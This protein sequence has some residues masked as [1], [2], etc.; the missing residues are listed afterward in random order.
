[1]KT[2]QVTGFG[3]PS[4]PLPERR[5]DAGLKTEEVRSAG[6]GAHMRVDVRTVAAKQEGCADAEAFGEV[7]RSSVGCH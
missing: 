2:S 1:M 4:L 3:V 6:V 7:H 5:V